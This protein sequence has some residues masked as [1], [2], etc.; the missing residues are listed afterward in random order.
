MAPIIE[1]LVETRRKWF[2]HVQRRPLE[3]PVGRV[4]Q[5]VD[6]PIIRGRGRPKKTIQ[7]TIRKDLAINNLTV[8]MCKDRTCWR[9]LT[10]IADPT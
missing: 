1:K 8:N 3:A 2:G 6:N 10:H 9:Q 7:E 5:M 4:D